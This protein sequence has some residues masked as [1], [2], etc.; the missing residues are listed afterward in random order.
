MEFL[1]H[2]VIFCLTFEELPNYCPKLLHHFTARYEGF[3]FSTF[4]PTLV[5]V[6]PFQ[7]SHPSGCEVVSYYGLDLYLPND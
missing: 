7:Y 1:G 5:I 4:S 6:C 3:N 2:M